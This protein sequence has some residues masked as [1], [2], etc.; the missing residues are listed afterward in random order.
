[1]Q[2]QKKQSVSNENKDAFLHLQQIIDSRQRVE[3]ERQ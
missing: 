3:R 2:Q 1:M